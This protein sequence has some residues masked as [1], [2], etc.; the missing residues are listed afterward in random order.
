MARFY[1]SIRG[2]RGKATRMGSA[3][4]GI[5]GHVRGWDIGAEVELSDENGRDVVRVYRTGGSNRCSN[6]TLIAELREDDVTP[7]GKAKIGTI[8]NT[9]AVG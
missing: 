2:N 9:D 3:K 4:S 5:T 7:Y 1:A 8:E 6:R